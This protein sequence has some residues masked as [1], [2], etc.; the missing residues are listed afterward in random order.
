[1]KVYGKLNFYGRDQTKGK[2]MMRQTENRYSVRNGIGADA[3]A[4]EV[5]R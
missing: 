1:M 3:L 2:D 5:S 4:L